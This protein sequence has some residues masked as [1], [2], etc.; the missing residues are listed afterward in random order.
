MEKHVTSE[1]AYLVEMERAKATF[2]ASEDVTSYGLLSSFGPK[3]VLGGSCIG[4]Q[5]L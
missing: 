3:R 2:G 5:I 4:T 1:L